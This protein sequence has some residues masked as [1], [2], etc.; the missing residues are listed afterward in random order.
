[1]I[2]KISVVI[3]GKNGAK[4]LEK[5]LNAL[6]EFDDI[7]FYDNGSSDQTMQIARKFKNVNLVEGE[8]L[9]FGKTKILAS[10]YAKNDWILNLDCD[11]VIDEDLKNSLL[12]EKLDENCVYLLNFNAFYKDIQVKHCGWSGQKIKRLYNKKITNYNE[13]KIHEKILDE[14]LKNKILKGNVAHY[15]F[16]SISDFLQKTDKYSDAY[17]LQN[18]GKKSSSPAKAYF[19]SIWFFIKNYFIRLGFLDGYAGLL[20]CYSGA[21][22]V[23][24]KYL[25]LYEK[26]LELKAKSK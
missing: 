26:N 8:F 6:R 25:K 23:F 11:E 22:G 24:Y 16:L 1:M 18:M 21:N 4:T 9:G 17:A 14:G 19:R 2:N 10:S 7:V 13:A 12:N 15:S 5:T 20:V 3:I